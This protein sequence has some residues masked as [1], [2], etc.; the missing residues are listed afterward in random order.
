M[1]KSEKFVSTSET[2]QKIFTKSP[3]SVFRQKRFYGH[4]ESNFNNPPPKIFDQKL[5]RNPETKTSEDVP[6][7]N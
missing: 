7:D 4:L 1:Q 2:E 3:N 5:Q 6:L